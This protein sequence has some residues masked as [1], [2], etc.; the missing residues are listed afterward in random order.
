MTWPSVRR[1][2]EESLSRGSSQLAVR[3]FWLSL[4]TVSPSYSQWPIEQIS[5]ITTMR[6]PIL[7][8]SCSFFSR[9]SHHPGLSAPIQ[10][11]FGFLRILAFPKT[12]IAVERKEICECECHT[13]HKLSKR[14]LTVGWLNTREK[15]WSRMCSNVCSDWLPGYIKVTLSVLELFKR[16]CYFPYN[17]RILQIGIDVL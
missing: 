16:A 7:Q 5:F 9:T 4:C 10:L 14:R 17:H 1:D 2:R 11:R 8:L 3:S 12:K 6:L 15:A 13:L